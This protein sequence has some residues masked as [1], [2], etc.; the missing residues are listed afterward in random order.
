V[1]RAPDDDTDIGAHVAGFGAGALLALVAW[2]LGRTGHLG[3]RAERA[4]GA[5]VPLVAGLAWAA[6]LVAA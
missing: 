2:R 1:Q 4:L 5:A 3:P 6:A